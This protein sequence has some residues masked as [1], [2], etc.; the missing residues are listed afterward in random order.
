MA[1]RQGNNGNSDRLYWSQTVLSSKI[2]ADGD[3]I[4]EIKSCMLLG[5]KAMSNLDSIFK[6]RDITLLTKVRYSQNYG[7]SSGHGWMW[8]LDYKE[9]W[10]QK[11]WWFWTAVLEKTLESPLNCKEIQPLHRKGDQSLVFIGR[12]DVEA[13]APMLWLPD[14]ENWPTGKDPDAGK[15]W[16]QEEKGMTEDEMAGQHHWLNG[17]EFE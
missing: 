3:F 8:K 6:S 13:K 11:N 1:N 9:S 5:R 16:R 15:N 17:H 12:T 2:T 4:H 14:A 10:A 7:F